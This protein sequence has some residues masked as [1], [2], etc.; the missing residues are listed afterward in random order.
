MSVQ[1]GWITVSGPHICVSTYKA[2][3]LV[4]NSK[5]RPRVLLATST[6]IST[7]PAKVRPRTKL[8]VHRRDPPVTGPPMSILLLTILLL[9]DDTS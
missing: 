5:T 1:K 2:A 4:R 3:S 8:V 6:T 7:K 9:F